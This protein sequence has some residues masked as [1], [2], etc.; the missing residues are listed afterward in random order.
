[1]TDDRFKRY[2]EAGNDFLEVARARAEDFL[3]E[4]AK[5]TESTQKQAQGQVDDLVAA[6]RRGTDQMIDLVR[7]EVESQLSQLG[8]VTKSEF[9][10]WK[11]RLG[12]SARK[13][14]A[15][16]TP[17]KKAAGGTE[18]APAAKK[19]SGTKAAPAAKKA[20]GTKAAASKATASKSS[21]PTKSAAKKSAAKRSPAKKTTA[22]KTPAKKTPAKKTTATKASG[23]ASK[24]PGS[25][26]S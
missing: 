10:A 15:D 4:L 2:Q 11:R 14:A 26:S 17:A 8:V 23:T 21:S 16:K 6:G 1:M 9:D 22:K 18:S 20:S 7:R 19:A 25:S 3:R 13:S 5:A 24:A 12:G